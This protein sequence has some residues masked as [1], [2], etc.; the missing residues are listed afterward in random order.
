MV[1]KAMEYMGIHDRCKLADIIFCV[2]TATFPHID[3]QGR[4]DRNSQRS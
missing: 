3:N 2:T 1:H 4:A